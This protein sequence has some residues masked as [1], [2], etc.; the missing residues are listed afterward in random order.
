[1]VDYPMNKV[2]THI[3]M[4]CASMILVVACERDSGLVVAE[5]Y[6]R[7]LERA[8]LK[9]VIGVTFALKDTYS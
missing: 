4:L 2:I 8:K 1:M 3:D 5:K 9:Q 6:R 7:V